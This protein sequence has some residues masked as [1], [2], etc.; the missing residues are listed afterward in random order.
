MSRAK[1]LVVGYVGVTIG[2]GCVANGD[3][4]EAFREGVPQA[5]DV[6]L[7]VPGG[8]STATARQGLEI[9]ANAIGPGTARY[10]RFSRDITSGVDGATASILGGIWFIV[11]LP[12]TTVDAKTAVWG[13]WQGNALD[14]AIYK[15]TAT[16]VGDAEYDYSLEGRPKAGGDFVV[17]LRGHGYG[18]SR[19]E[20]RSGWFQWDN[21]ARRT[22]D[23]DRAKD[24]G[25]AKVTYDLR[26]APAA[27][28]VELRPAA[29]SADIAVTHDVGG[30]GALEITA[31]ADIDDSKTT[32]LENV[33]LSSRWDTSGAG[34]AD[35]ALANGDLPLAVSATECWSISFARL[36]YKD[37]VDFEPAFGDASACISTAQ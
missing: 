27:I 9:A 15:F 32:K 34:R 29:G 6:A 20:H 35:I 25:T 19:P 3:D 12:P 1:L 10:Y 37:T 8:S 14:P 7:R 18:K 5:D 30:A 17:V 23:P 31:L 11:H 22:L 21:D 24:T 4:A 36:Y 16:E 26:Q 33:H 2:A 28:R 13:P